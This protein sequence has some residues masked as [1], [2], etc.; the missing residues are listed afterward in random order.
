MLSLRLS[1]LFVLF[2]GWLSACELVADFDRGKLTPVEQNRDAG[3]TNSD[4]D[5]GQD[6]ATPD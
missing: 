3:V 5:A 1:F 6:A 4:D 2:C